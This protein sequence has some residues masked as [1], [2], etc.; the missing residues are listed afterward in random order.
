MVSGAGR[1]LKCCI[2]RSCRCSPCRELTEH[3]RTEGNT[4]VERVCFPASSPGTAI[5][6]QVGDPACQQ[7]LIFSGRQLSNGHTLGDCGLQPG[8]LVHLVLRLVGD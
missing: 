3:K 4:G 1:C 8:S 2:V 6:Q 7:A 5:Q